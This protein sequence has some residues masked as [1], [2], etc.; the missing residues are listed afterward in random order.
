YPTTSLM[1][2]DKGIPDGSLTVF[3]TQPL[4]QIVQ[5]VLILLPNNTQFKPVIETPPQIIQTIQPPPLQSVAYPGP[6][7]PIVPVAPMECFSG[8]LIVET[9]EGPKRMIELTTGDKVL[10]VE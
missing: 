4:S 7:V 6:A 8:D 10:S 3:K 5:E 1:F 2:L 9:L